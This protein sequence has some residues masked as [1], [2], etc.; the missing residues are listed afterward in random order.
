SSKKKELSARARKAS[1]AACSTA[2][3]PLMTSP[4]TLSQKMRTLRE[5]IR[6]SDRQDGAEPEE[7]QAEHCLSCGADLT[8]SKS[9]DRYRVCHSCGFHFHLTAME[10]IAT[11]LDPG[12]FREADRGVTAID[13]ISFSGKQSYRSRVIQA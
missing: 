8:A 4:D 12:S 10:R 5:L 6:R 2:P 9:Y 13:P 3:G 1:P 11:L 7:Q